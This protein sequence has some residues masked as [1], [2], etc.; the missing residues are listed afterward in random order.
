MLL[1]HSLLLTMIT[2]YLKQKS[3][4]IITFWMFVRV[5]WLKI[6]IHVKVCLRG[7]CAKKKQQKNF[8]LTEESR[9]NRNNSNFMVE[10]PYRNVTKLLSH[11]RKKCRSK[12]EKCRCITMLIKDNVKLGSQQ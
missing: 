4:N 3:S 5:D 7:M 9:K 8:S 2:K 10:L 11:C 6:V 12:I 1:I